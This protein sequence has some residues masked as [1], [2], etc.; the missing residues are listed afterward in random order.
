MMQLW[1]NVHFDEASLN[2]I[3]GNFNTPLNH[4]LHNLIFPKYA[5]NIN[6]VHFDDV[7][8]WKGGGSLILKESIRVD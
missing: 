5:Q 1:H 6:D 3:C 2:M 4:I 7:S 8:K